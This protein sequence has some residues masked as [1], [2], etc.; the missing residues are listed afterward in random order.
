MQ[1]IKPHTHKDR[2][3]VLLGVVPLLK[4]HFRD[5]FIALAIDGSYARNEDTDFSDLEIIVFVNEIAND[6][7]YNLWKIIN[8]LLVEVVVETKE[9]YIKKYLDVSDV[10]YASGA[11][12]LLPVINEKFIDDINNYRPEDVT[13]KCL[14]QVKNK[15]NR[16]QE[17]TAKLLNNIDQNNKGGVPIIFS[18]LVKELLIVLSYLNE[19]PYVTLGKY[20]TQAKE[21]SLKPEGFDA[22]TDIFIRGT[23]Q[24]TNYLKAIV[25]KVFTNLEKICEEKK[26]LSYS[27]DFKDITKP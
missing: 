17:I 10:W 13:S 8:G 21:F 6:K 5:N 16:F 23:Y 26:L 4:D 20:I 18:D 2:E 19:T 1:G 15:W 24:D 27:R 22:L 9:G 25:T 7:N 11:S 3:K 14:K 12:R